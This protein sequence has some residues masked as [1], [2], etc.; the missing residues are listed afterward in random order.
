MVYS[1]QADRSV[2]FLQEICSIRAG[3]S[4]PWLIC[5]DFNLIYWAMDKSSSHLN[6]RLMGKF[7]R[8][9]QDLEPN[10]LHLEGLVLHGNKSIKM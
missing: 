6:H 5:G 10:E 4:D 7:R 9:L 3:R 8:L 1:P 2:T